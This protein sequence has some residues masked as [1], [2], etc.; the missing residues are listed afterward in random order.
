VQYSSTPNAPDRGV[1]RRFRP[2][3]GPTLLVA[4]LLPALCW[5]GFWQLSR[6][7]EK[8]L[9]LARFEALRQAE[10]VAVADLL[11]AGAP[12]FQRVRLH[13]RFDPAH[14]LLLD[15]RIHA[16]RPGVELLQ[17]F[18][19]DGGQWLLVNRGW[20]PWP[21]RRTAPAFATPGEPLALNA[22]VYRPP[23]RPF[24]LTQVEGSDWPRLVN[25]IDAAA[26]WTALGR[27]GLPV[28]LRLESAPAAY[29]TDWPAVAMGPER[30]LGYAVQWFALAATLLALF[31]WFGIHNAREASHVLARHA[32]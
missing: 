28:E 23:G 7:E 17:P 10:P 25:R 16:G 19:D 31:V 27:T 11:A 20:L 5:L 13:G 2:G 15:N 4:L 24:L 8:R 26:L 6:A 29:A 32:H 22:W 14:S 30:H 9:L 21:D 12:A 18:R 1:L 3:L